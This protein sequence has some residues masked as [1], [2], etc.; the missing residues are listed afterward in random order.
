[1]AGGLVSGRPDAHG[2][3]YKHA[4]AIGIA[5]G[6]DELNVDSGQFLKTHST[7]SK[8]WC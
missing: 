3:T 7:G 2:H 1:M 5:Q 6:T 4:I 8:P